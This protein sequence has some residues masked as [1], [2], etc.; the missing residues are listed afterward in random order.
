MSIYLDHNATSPL[1]AVCHQA[2]MKEYERVGN[3]SAIHTLGR[4]AKKR[5]HAYREAVAGMV[6]AS[7]EQTLFTSGG[8]E[9]NGMVLLSAKKTGYHI[10]CSSTEHDSVRSYAHPENY[11]AVNKDGVIDLESLENQLKDPCNSAP[12]LVSVMLAN[13]ETGVIQPVAKIVEIVKRYSYKGVP[14]KVHTDATQALGKMPVG[15][16]ALGV[17]YM[18]LS[19][20]KLGGPKGVGALVFSSNS[21][22]DPVFTG[23]L[24][25][26]GLRAGTENLPAI[27][28]FAALS[29]DV[30]NQTLLEQ[31]LP[32]RETLERALQSIAPDITIYGKTAERLPNISCF[33]VASLSQESQLMAL[34][35]AQIYVSAGAACASRKLHPSHVLLA[36]GASPESAKSAIRVS[37]GWTSKPTDVDQFMQT[38]ATLYNRVQH[39]HATTQNIARQRII[40]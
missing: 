10:L 13:N 30:N 7:P 31:T 23:G 26:M 33:S 21:K 15:F 38:W 11:L 25:E 16:D 1:R 5:L 19:A 40:S 20:H 3:A 22:P 24:Q 6:S 28:G 34:D 12:Y 4:E 35:L 8:T 9:A 27:A 32:L 36:M 37:F 18:T 29:C 39:R 17:D 2:L 14:A